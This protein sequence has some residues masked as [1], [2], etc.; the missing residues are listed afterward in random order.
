M[1]M[2]Q[3]DGIMGYGERAEG[4]GPT[5]CSLPGIDAHGV[6]KATAD[7]IERRKSLRRLILRRAPT[8]EAGLAPFG[9][10]QFLPIGASFLARFYTRPREAAE[11]SAARSW[12]SWAAATSLQPLAF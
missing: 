4:S 5:C 6:P 1:W 3:G 7:A 8:A 2:G 12:T 11:R 10:L 9:M